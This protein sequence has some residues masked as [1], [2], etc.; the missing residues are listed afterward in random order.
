[1]ITAHSYKNKGL[2]N[3]DDLSKIVSLSGRALSGVLSSFSKR[4]GTPLIIKAGT[5]DVSWD[6]ELF[7]R[8]KQL[9]MINPRLT[10]EDVS[11][12]T[13]SL[14]ELLS[15]EMWCPWC[16]YTSTKDWKGFMPVDGLFSPCPKCG[17]SGSVEKREKASYGKL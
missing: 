5:I 16:G 11:E 12:I 17:S 3:S 1:M 13:A 9:W 2:F 7:S 4:E 10:K 6:G 8:P 14:E 15:T